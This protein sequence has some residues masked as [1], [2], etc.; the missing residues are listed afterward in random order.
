MPPS[1]PPP[2][3][4]APPEEPEKASRGEHVDVLLVGRHPDCDLMLTH[5]S[6][7]RFHLQICS[8]PSSRGFFVVDLSSVH[9]M[10]VSGKRIEPM[11]SVEMKEGDVLKIGVSSRVYH[12]HWIPI[13]CAY[14]LRVFWAMKMEVLQR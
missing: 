14:D 3:P 13:S 9:E 8:K 10:W 7:S 5:P 12:L 4:L 11:V 1:T 6:I 2:T